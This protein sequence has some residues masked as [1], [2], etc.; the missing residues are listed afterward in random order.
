MNKNRERE[1]EVLRK[2][3]ASAKFPRIHSHADFAV[4]ESG[5]GG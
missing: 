4:V 5:T 1:T 2:K 3:P